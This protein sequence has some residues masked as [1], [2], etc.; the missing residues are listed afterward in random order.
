MDTM[1]KTQKMEEDLAYGSVEK[2]FRLSKGYTLAD[3]ANGY[4]TVSHLSEF[5][6]GKT[7]L[8]TAIFFGILRNI[9]VSLLEFESQY[10]QTLQIGNITT[11]ASEISKAYIERNIAKLKV[12]LGNLQTAKF[13]QKD[14]VSLRLD[15]IRVKAVIKLIDPSFE[16]SLHDISYLTEYLLQLKAWGHYEIMLFGYTV[17]LISP[18]NIV[19]LADRL[20]DTTMTD[21]DLPVIKMDV[22]RAI[23]NII[24]FFTKKGLYTEANRYI[25]F[26][27]RANIHDYYTYEKFNL[28]Y[29]E[30]RLQ[31]IK[32]NQEALSTLKEC[33]KFYSFCDCFDMA[34]ILEL[35]IAELEKQYG[36]K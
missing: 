8:S 24:D 25:Q 10:N 13:S 17:C 16:I 18:P 29:D 11:Y 9:H 1:N 3:A 19:K 27:K 35:E 6:N 21:F 32:G 30:A 36:R 20:I 7:M 31:F 12:I 22:Y 33:Q 26:L 28:V 2:R 15:E 5:E 4:T 34:N 14:L 23:L